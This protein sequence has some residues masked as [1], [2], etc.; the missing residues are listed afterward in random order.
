MTNT[1]VFVAN[2][3]YALTS[4]RIPLIERFIDSGWTVVV[5]TSDDAESVS[6]V[7][8][9]VVL[10]PVY[11]NR[12]GVAF[13]SDMLAYQRLSRIYRK[14]KPSLI[15]HFH[16]KPVI[17]GTLVSKR[18]LG[19][20]VRVVNTITGLGHAFIE[21]GLVSKLAGI[22][23]KYA[24]PKSEMTIFQNN[25]DFKLFLSSRW[26]EHK[27]SQVIASSGV[28]IVKFPF[29]NRSK[30]DGVSLVVVML[31]RLLRQKGVPEFA[32]VAE[33]VR[34]RF[35]SARFLLAGEEDLVHPDSVSAA[36]ILN[37]QGIEYLGR[38]DDVLPLL[39]MADLFLFPSHREGV[40]RA[41]LEAA[42]TGLPTV[43]YEV[44]GVKEAVDNGKTGYLVDFKDV[45]ALCDR[46]IELLETEKLRLKMGGEARKLIEVFFDR[47]KVEDRYI[48]TYQRL[49]ISVK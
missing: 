4:S 49:N 16:A 3:G 46:T 11:F 34:K 23:Y 48:K 10:E 39:E 30:R 47:R 13:I 18:L 35:P 19:N 28:D 31:A 25:D 21:G 44:P 2:R 32:K 20:S 7:K 15:H 45:D 8:L 33:K 38:L 5:A 14:W 43:G 22:G 37:H 9:G 24:L 17:L 27:S 26:V 36:S 12:G 6:L 29:F 41:V 1:V 40:P 42:A